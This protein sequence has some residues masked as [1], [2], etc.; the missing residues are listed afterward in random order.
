MQAQAGKRWDTE[1]GL[2]VEDCCNLRDEAAQVASLGLDESDNEDFDD[3]DPGRKV[4][5]TSLYDI[6]GVKPNASPAEIKKQYYKVALKLHPDKN[7]DDP[8]AGVKFQK[9]AQAYQV[10]SDPKLRERYD[11]IGAEAMNDQAL[12]NIDPG[13]FFSMLFG[14]E[15]F[16]KYIG[17]LYL[18]MQTDHIAKDLQRDFDRHQAAQGQDGQPP[19]DVI[20]NSIEREMRWSSD[21]KDGKIKR[22]QFAREVSCASELVARLDRFC[23][24][25]NQDGWTA[26]VLQEAQ[27]LARVSFGGR[28][29][30]TIGAAY[31]FAAEQFFTAMFGNFTLDGQLQSWKDSTH[32]A[33]VKVQAACSVARSAMAVKE[34]HDIA[35]PGMSSDD[36]GK[37]DEAA[38]HALSSFE[39]SL[40]TFLQTIW[41]I[42]QMD[43]ENTLRK[44]CD[45]VLKD[46]SV[47]WQIRYRRAVAMQRLGQIFR[48]AGQ[49]ELKDLSNSTV[50]KAQLEEALYSAIREK[51]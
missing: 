37:R 36:Q 27:E 16:E 3:D 8:E 51:G 25:R 5:D 31:E 38:K 35:G 46:V 43:I 40:P 33:K 49:V 47:P 9:L 32:A 26:S 30:R 34:M 48:D 17:K 6:I 29:L 50:A 12:P 24:G 42:S 28:L 10:L 23:I 13:L 15:Q 7:Q 14:A 18:A 22:Q 21:K 4:A 1:T 45:K 39:G 19:R 20:G 41:D 44:V 11:T 2:W